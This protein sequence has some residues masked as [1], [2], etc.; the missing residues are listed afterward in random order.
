MP[1]T[2][3]LNKLAKTAQKHCASGK[4]FR[5][6]SFLQSRDRDFDGTLKGFY[7]KRFTASG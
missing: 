6:V 7:V 4:C 2:K 5:R 1:D 3:T